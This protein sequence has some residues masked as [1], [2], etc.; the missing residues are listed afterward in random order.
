NGAGVSGVAPR[1]TLVGFRLIADLFSAEDEAEAMARGMDLIQVKNNSWGI[2][3]GYPWELGQT[4][5]LFDAAMSQA[6]TL[7]RG[8]LGT[9]SVWSAGNGRHQGDQGG[10]D[11]YASNRY[12]IT[13]GAV[14]NKGALAF[15]SETGA[16]LCVVAP[17]AENR[18]G[19]VTTD[20]AGIRGYND[21][22]NLKNL[23]DI[24]YTNDFSGTSAAAP[25]VAG[26]AAL[27]LEANPN[28]NWRDVKEIL[29][30]SS[31]QIGGSS[32]WVSRDARAELGLPAVKHH[33]SFG[34]GL[35]NARAAVDMAKTWTSLGPEVEIVKSA[36]S[37]ESGPASIKGG[38]TILIPEETK[39]TLK[40]NRMDLDFSASTALRV[41]HVAVTVSI[42]NTK[43]G[44]MTVK[45]VSPSGVVSVLAPAS[46]Q[47]VG[48]DYS[49]WTFTSL[50]HWGESSRGVWSIITHEPDDGST[51]KI[52]AAAI[53]LFGTAWPAAEIVT[54]PQ[55]ALLATGD[56][57]AFTGAVSGQA[58]LTRQWLKNG[59]VIAGAAG[60]SFSIASVK[61]A[62]AGAYDYIVSNLTGL[63]GARAL[64]GV[65]DRVVASQNLVAGRTA[66]FTARTAGPST[67]R[68]QW[69][70]GAQMLEDDGRVTGARSPV[71]TLRNVSNADAEDYFCR[72]SLGELSLDTLR[73]TLGII[74]KPVLEAPDP[75][76]FFTFA[77]GYVE[78]Q[79]NA[80]NAPDSF[81]ARGLPPGLKLDPKTGLISGRPDKPGIYTVTISASNAAGS[82]APV[83]AVVEI[84]PLP[85]GTTGVF[86]GLLDRLF[87]YNGGHGGFVT[88]TVNESGRFTGRI[89][90]GGFY[91]TNFTGR[92]DIDPQAQAP[93]ATVLIPRAA[94]HP[95]LELF[96]A[97]VDGVLEGD[98][99]APGEEGIRVRGFRQ[100]K[101]A[102]PASVA[103][104]YN[105]PLRTV[106]SDAAYPLGTGHLSAV[107]SAQGAVNFSG[108]LAD[109]TTLTGSGI[110]AS[111]GELPLHRM[112]YNN[113]GSIQGLLI[114]DRGTPSFEAALDWGKN[115]QAPGSTRSY[116]AGFPVH[117]IGGGGGRYLPPATG[118]PVMG[119]PLL[120]NNAVLV[121]TEGGLAAPFSQSL[122]LGAGNKVTLPSGA[123]NPHQ[124]RVT[125]NSAN[126]LVTGTGKAMDIDPDNPGLNRQRQGSMSALIIQ[127]EARAEG[128][129]LLPQ[130]QGKTSPIWSGR[131]MLQA[132]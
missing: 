107:L 123:A 52:N 114:L 14:T 40:V 117:D 84:A 99:S 39:K 18:A 49:D 24:D 43:R 48:S 70:K 47:D 71:L 63:D 69:F 75:G 121:F 62:D 78:Y 9:I 116:A 73:G 122:T 8:G 132:D 32:G 4:G 93:E 55:D 16:H 127:G 22:L 72:V 106:Q 94:P 60:D 113:T 12:C 112:L 98:L 17:S 66:T 115:T 19:I 125:L 21:G 41:E 74:Q 102:T 46:A 57:L 28:L 2:L 103:G 50:R 95:P 1:A 61:L 81:T 96:F 68:H 118:Q 65:V 53:R 34:G 3:D 101:S 82:S 86:T 25:V 33:H 131:V 110:P 7:G 64:L 26:V 31:T 128:Y 83:T 100:V 59:K 79:V 130:D 126:G 29:L 11:G 36:V 23:G 119:L 6:A 105:M 37:T 51:G 54:A 120:D 10:K 67:L 88:L 45:L 38:T 20:L 129:F 87:Y 56:S 58:P 91:T 97:L 90:R 5:A 108:K 104:R 76:S 85:Q 109:G 42:T 13:V 111:G 124:I 44:D 27:M 35:V 30:R 80:D 92:L 15:Y 89:I 77:S